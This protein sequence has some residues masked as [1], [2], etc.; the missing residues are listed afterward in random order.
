MAAVPLLCEKGMFM[1]KLHVAAGG[2]V[3]LLLAG[4][5]AWAGL[6]KTTLVNIDTVARNAYGAL[7]AARA[8][9][10]TVQYIGCAVLTYSTGNP[11]IVCNARNAAGT[12]VSCSSNAPSMVQ[13]ATALADG[14]AINFSWDE[15]GKCT[16]LF[17]E[18]SSE[19][20][21][22]QP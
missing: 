9:S 1:R 7:G 15:A 4:T 18:N 11:S 14:S 3:A 8:S 6:K 13:A 2:L 16:Y 22:K 10:D 21:T 19:H 20:G 12:Y 17:V 5:S